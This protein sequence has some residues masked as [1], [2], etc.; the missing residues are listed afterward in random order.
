[1]SNPQYGYPF[2]IG[3]AVIE[4][5]AACPALKDV[6]IRENPDKPAD[7]QDGKRLIIFKDMSDTEHTQ[8]GNADARVYSFQVGVIA[9][10]DAARETAHADYYAAKRAVREAILVM[11]RNGARITGQVSEN[12]VIYQIETLDVG[13]CLILGNFDVPYREPNW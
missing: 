9:R 4:A 1:M 12:S 11:T 10:T 8:S 6:P 13:G 7:L 2:A 5:L 3:A